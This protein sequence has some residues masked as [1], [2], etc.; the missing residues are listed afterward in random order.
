MAL[1][2]EKFFAAGL[3]RPLAVRE[4]DMDVGLPVSTAYHKHCF[5]R[6]SHTGRVERV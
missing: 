5:C 4:D 6:S 1:N 2:V 3:G